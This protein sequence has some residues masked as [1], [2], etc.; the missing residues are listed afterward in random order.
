[1]LNITLVPTLFADLAEVSTFFFVQFK[2]CFFPGPEREKESVKYFL[3]ELVKKVQKVASFILRY[4]LTGLITLQLSNVCKQLN[5]IFSATEKNR[6][7]LFVAFEIKKG[8][9]K[10]SNGNSTER[11]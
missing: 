3:V 2:S 7:K 1:M 10:F 4:E 9:V 5:E 11:K 8:Q 6:K